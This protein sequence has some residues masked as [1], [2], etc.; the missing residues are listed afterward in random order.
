MFRSRFFGLGSISAKA[1]VAARGDQPCP[2]GW[3]GMP[4]A[5]APVPRSAASQRMCQVCFR[6]LPTASPGCLAQVSRSGLGERV[7]APHQQ[8]HPA[9]LPGSLPGQAS[10]RWPGGRPLPF[11]PEA[12]KS[13]RAALSM[14]SR[15]QGVKASAISGVYLP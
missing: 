1:G 9:W 10:E 7:S 13:A 3:A 6:R 12:E 15:A 11:A 2:L 5:A 14:G 4:R 8:V